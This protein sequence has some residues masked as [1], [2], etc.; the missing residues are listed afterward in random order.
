[1]KEKKQKAQ[2]QEQMFKAELTMS[3]ISGE[4]ACDALA[5]YL[6]SA[7]VT[8]R[9]GG[10]TALRDHLGRTWAV[11]E[12]AEGGTCML[13]TP[14]LGYEDMDDFLCLVAELRG[15]GAHG[16]EDCGMRLFASLEGRSTRV[17]SNL[18]GI[19][20]G[21][22]ELLGHALR[23]A[24][25]GATSAETSVDE[26]GMAEVLPMSV[27]CDLDP[28][29]MRACIQL[30]CAVAAQAVNQN[31]ASSAPY[32]YENERYAMRCWLIRMGLNGD[33]FKACRAR[34]LARLE[35]DASYKG[36]RKPARQ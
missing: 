29:E 22:A 6:P 35:G 10:K 32:A 11:T 1:M 17:L 24:T 21:K 26:E 23:C 31:R 7:Q 15:R 27:A 33:E 16:G 20:A 12:G 8:E 19:L 13:S 14:A 9:D 18:R 25:D 30:G 28:D 5:E 34:L 36:G 3:G 4:G 2:I